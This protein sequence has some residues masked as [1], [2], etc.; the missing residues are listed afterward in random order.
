MGP[1]V[2]V[3]IRAV[4]DRKLVHPN[5][6]V[7]NW[8]MGNAVAVTDPAGF[9]KIDKSKVRFRIDGAV[10]LAMALGL[11]ARDRQAAAVDIE[12]LIIS[13]C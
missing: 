4:A 13:E 7:L 1:A 9:Q 11:K 6:P 12:T 2:S 8:N 3:F 10:A 5:H